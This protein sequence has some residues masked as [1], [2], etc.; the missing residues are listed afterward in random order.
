VLASQFINEQFAHR[1]GMGDELIG[2]GHAFEMDPALE[3]G[4]LWE[5]ADALLSRTCF[6]DAPLKYM[7]PT[8]HMTGDIFKGHVMNALFNLTSV[9]TRQ[10]IHLIGVLTEAIHTP[11]LQD[12][13]LAIENARYLFNYARHFSEEFQLKP[14]GRI[15]QRAAEVLNRT[16]ALL[17]QIEQTGLMAAISEG[18]F[19]GIKRRPDGG[20]GLDGVIAKGDGYLNPFFDLALKGGVKA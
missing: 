13:Y 20:K 16:V 4:L 5:M 7:P 3:D 12:R 18:V 1:S 10:Q 17:E 8:R 14:D 2:L 15:E 19:A 6:P 11:F 9:A